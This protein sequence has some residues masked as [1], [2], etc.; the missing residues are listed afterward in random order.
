MKNY[1]SRIIHFPNP[2][3]YA[4]FIPLPPLCFSSLSLFALRISFVL[5]PPAVRQNVT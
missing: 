3:P 2:D 5:T 4:L 1:L